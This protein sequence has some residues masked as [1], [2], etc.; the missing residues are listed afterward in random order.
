VTGVTTTNNGKDQTWTISGA[1]YGNGEYSASYNNTVLSNASYYG[2]VRCFD[3]V[4]DGYS[5]HSSSVQTGIVTLNMPEKILLDSYELRHR[6]NANTNENHAPRDWKL[7][8]SNDGTTWVVLDT[9]ANQSYS[10]DVQ[11]DEASKRTYTVSGNTTQ[12]SRY[13]LNITANDGG[14]HLVIGQWKLF[15]K[16]TRTAK[17]TDPNGDTYSLGQTQNDIYIEDTGEYALEVT[18]SDQSAIVETNVTGTIG[19]EM[20]ISEN[21]VSINKFTT[22]NASEMFGHADAKNHAFSKDKS[23]FV[24]SSDTADGNSGDGK[25]FIYKRGSDGRYTLDTTLNAVTGG[26]KNFGH[27]LD[28]NDSG[29]RLVIS[30]PEI[31][32]TDGAGRIHVYDR[33]STSASLANYAY[34]NS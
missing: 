22:T 17:L 12:Y 13:R 7:E 30:E 31:S 4:N 10:P 29:T 24:T 23:I 27:S 8:A 19:P 21:I 16:N 6:P 32:W 25:V 2:P 33:A 14:T 9:Q 3:K 34:D 5:F 11:G 1:S 20:I 15:E 18:N 26:T 28:I